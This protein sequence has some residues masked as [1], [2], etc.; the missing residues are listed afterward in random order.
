MSV[1]AA[2]VREN[3]V[4]RVVDSNA[5]ILIDD[6]ATTFMHKVVE[7]GKKYLVKETHVMVKSVDD[8]TSKP[9]V[10]WPKEAPALLSY[11]TVDRCG[12]TPCR[13]DRKYHTRANG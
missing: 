1:G 11:K 8:E 6:S 10:L 2:V 12:L 13:Q 7:L 4:G 9:S 3:N 5:I